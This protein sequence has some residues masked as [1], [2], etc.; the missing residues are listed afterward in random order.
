M[1]LQAATM[2]AKFK[3][4]IHDGLA[5]VFASDTDPQADPSWA[6]LADA[7][8]DIAMDIVTEITTNAQVIPGQ[9]VVGTFVGVG[10]GPTTGVTTTPG[11]IL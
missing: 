6:K 4:R 1:P 11:Q 9:A 5:R 3:S 2:K 7:I 10:S 8:S